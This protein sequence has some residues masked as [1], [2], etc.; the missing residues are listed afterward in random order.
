MTICHRITTTTILRQISVAAIFVTAM[1]VATAFTADAKPKS[2]AQQ[3][4]QCVA[5]LVK[6][7]KDHGQTPDMDAIQGACCININGTL[8]TQDDGVTFKDCVFADTSA[9]RPTPPAGATVIL[10]PGSNTRAGN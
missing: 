1:S 5:D 9:G 7:N 2:P 3:F 6:Y 8:M 10:P 4:S